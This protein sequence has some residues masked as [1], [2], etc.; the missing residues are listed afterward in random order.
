MNAID[1]WKF[2][3]IIASANSMDNIDEA[4]A[5]LMKLGQILICNKHSKEKCA[6]CPLDVSFCIEL[7]QYVDNATKN[8]QE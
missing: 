4:G 2:E 5:A 3:E 7:R 6:Y 8:A 1:A